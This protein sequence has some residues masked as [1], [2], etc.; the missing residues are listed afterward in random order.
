MVLF[1]DL[2]IAKHLGYTNFKVERE[3]YRLNSVSLFYKWRRKVMCYNGGAVSDSQD[4]HVPPHHTHFP[5]WGSHLLSLIF[6]FLFCNKETM[7]VTAS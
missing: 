7:I 2:I 6:S 5:P 4:I 1:I 3:T